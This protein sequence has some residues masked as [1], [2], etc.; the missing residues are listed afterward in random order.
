MNIFQQFFKSLYSPQTVAKFRFQG[1]GK[2]ILYVFVLMMITT[3]IAAYQLGSTISTVVQQFQ[4]DL[5]NELPD[6]EIKNSVLIS[7][8]DEP[9]YITQNGDLFIFDSSGT[10]T[11][12]D[13]EKQYKNALALLETEA[14]FVSDGVAESFRYREFGNVNFTKEQV[15]E[16]TETVVE[17]LP[18]IISIVVFILFLVLTTLK[19][20]GIFVLTLFGIII[21]KNTETALSYKQVWILC[22]YAVTLPTV[23]FAI[24][25]SLNIVIPLSFTL[26]WI[27]AVIMLYLIFKEIPKPKVEEVVEDPMDRY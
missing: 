6:F 5:Q 4:V 3:S 17:L 7:D 18:L 25:D 15:E 22:A 20:I 10:L 23:F 19:Y 2:T 9:L 24:T 21:R 27:V 26:Y 14:V 11:V 1:I 8:L 13:I 16:L 12:S